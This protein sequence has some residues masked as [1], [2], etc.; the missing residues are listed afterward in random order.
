LLLVG[1]TSR[2]PA[3]NSRLTLQSEREKAIMDSLNK[4][5]GINDT[6]LHFSFPPIEIK[7]DYQYKN[8]K[9]EK[10]YYQ[11]YEDV[12][13]T[14]PLSKIVSSEIKLV[15]SEL[16]SIYKTKAQRKAYLKWYEKHTFNTYVDTLKSLNI[17]QIKIFIKLIDR[18][19]GN[20]PFELI[21]KYRGGLDAVLWQITANAL[22]VNLKSE[23]DPLEDKMIEDIIVRFY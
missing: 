6:M 16:D 3:Q 7:G 4:K 12:K 13:R 20:S 23:Y 15:N 11:L 22:L 5:Q 1:I 2:L 17:R 21:K 9:E 8:R 10:K 19:T 14:Y 18:E